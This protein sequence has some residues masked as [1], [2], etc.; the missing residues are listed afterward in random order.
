ML[1]RGHHLGQGQPT[2]NP[3][4]RRQQCC[5]HDTEAK[6]H[7]VPIAEIKNPA[8]CGADTVDKFSRLADGLIHQP[9]RGQVM[10][11]IQ[12]YI[13]EA[14]KENASGTQR[15]VV[16][17]WASIIDE[18][19]SKILSAHFIVLSKKQS[20]EM[21]DHNGPAGSF[22]S[23]IKLC[24]ALGLILDD[25]MNAI[26]LV[27]KIRNDFAHDI[28]VDLDDEPL[29]SQCLQL[30]TTFDAPATFRENPR[31]SF[32]TA[33]GSL[34]MILHNRLSSISRSTAIV[35]KKKM[36]LRTYGD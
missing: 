32:S 26:N 16:L 19:L 33:C 10:H 27:R 14:N 15:G 36:S 25:E 31:L 34:M 17:V 28:N 22:S 4:N 21:F 6:A 9:M 18:T 24:F 5:R 1:R 30:G 20:I 2:K 13:D 12:K 11:D 29:R 23:K 8:L 7:I 3:T 35:S